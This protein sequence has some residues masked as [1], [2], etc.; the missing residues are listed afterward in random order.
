MRAP[1]I[2]KVWKTKIVKCPHCGW[3]M[4]EWFPGNIVCSQC[5]YDD[6]NY[7]EEQKQG[8]K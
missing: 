3:Q 6:G 7:P 4:I 1:E 8:E 2:P 5:G